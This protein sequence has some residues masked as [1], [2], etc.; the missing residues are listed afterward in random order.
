MS[1]VVPLPVPPRYQLDPPKPF[2]QRIREDERRR[3]LRDRLELVART[4]GLVMWDLTLL[5]KAVLE[6]VALVERDGALCDDPSFTELLKA[7]SSAATLVLAAV[8][9]DDHQRAYVSAAFSSKPP[10]EAAHA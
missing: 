9:L 3:V 1:N 10:G 6:A 4:Q 2:V 7:Y 8:P 5:K